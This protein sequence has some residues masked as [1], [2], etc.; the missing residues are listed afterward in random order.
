VLD[1][2]LERGQQ[3]RQPLA[4]LGAADEQHPELLGVAVR[5]RRR[6]G[7]V[8]AVRDHLVAAAEPAPPGPGGGL[9]DG[10]PRV[11]LVELAARAE[12]VGDPV[13]HRLR[14]VGVER[15]DHGGVGKRAGVGGQHRRR[16]LVDVDDIEAP[17]AKLAAHRRHRVGKDREVGDRAVGGEPDRPAERDQVV[18]ALANLGAGAVQEPGAAI[19][20]V[21][22]GE[23]PD[24]VAA[25]DELACES[26]DMAVD[27]ARIGPRIGADDCDSHLPNGDDWRSD[28]A[29][30]AT[31]D[32][33]DGH[34]QVTERSPA[35]VWPR[36]RPR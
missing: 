35:F 2:R 9:G 17:G 8:D 36:P 26:L 10:D 1:E 30:T 7:D 20:R 27:A 24:L 21:V 4:L 3:D 5:A 25:L 19:R 23:H 11:E 6:R 32:I 14:R 28:R 33:P 22:G 15:P 29:P 18:G 16:R 12:E 31:T 13:R 34:T